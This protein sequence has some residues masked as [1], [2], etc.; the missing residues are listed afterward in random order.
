MNKEE[1][2]KRIK[3]IGWLKMKRVERGENKKG[4]KIRKDYGTMHKRKENYINKINT[5]DHFTTILS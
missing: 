3:K 5:N 1:R 2:L 4:E